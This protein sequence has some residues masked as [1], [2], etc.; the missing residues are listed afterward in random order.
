MRRDILFFVRGL[1]N[2]HLIQGKERFFMAAVDNDF[3][4]GLS[5]VAERIPTLKLFLN[6]RANEKIFCVGFR[7]DYDKESAALEEAWNALQG[8]LDGFAFSIDGQMPDVCGVIQVREDKAQD[9]RFKLYSPRGWAHFHPRTPESSKKW[10]DRR[11]KLLERFL[12]YFG[13]ATAKDLAG[14]S[15][16]ECQLRYSSKMFHCG[17]QSHNY[18]IEYLCKFSALEGIVCGPAINNK[19]KT[20]TDR[21]SQLFSK[22]SRNIS[23][24]IKTLWKFRCEASHQARAFSNSLAIK[25]VDI[26]YYLIGGIVFALDHVDTVNTI[27]D[28]WQRAPQYSLPDYAL[29]ERPADMP[30]VPVHNGII[31]TT[32]GFRA[33]GDVIDKIYAAPPVPLDHLS[34]QNNKCS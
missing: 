15:D 33:I 12:I 8:I 6:Q 5:N 16:L 4:Q 20:L 29:L 28:L 7:N 22:S 25:V 31:E 1:P 24:E 11:E 17:T 27:D 19:R 9:G 18:G 10:A 32:A 34:S 23:N 14:Q 21:L 13:L 30:K 3:L 26:E 2:D